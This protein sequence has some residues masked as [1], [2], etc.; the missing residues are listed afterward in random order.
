V[1]TVATRNRHLDASPPGNDVVGIDASGEWPPEGDYVLIE[2]T[3]TGI[4]MSPDILARA[5]EPFFTTKAV[6]T[7]SGLGLSQVFGVARQSG[8]GMHIESTLGKG[9]SVT[10]FVPRG[11]AE[12]MPVAPAAPALVARPP[13]DVTVLL[14]DDDSP[15]R[16]TTA[17]IVRGLGYTVV[18]AENGSEALSVLSG[19][20]RVDL[21]LT[22]VAMPGMSGP[23]LA[24]RAQ[25]VRPGLPTVFISGYADPQ[26]IAG[27]ARLRRFVRKPFRAADLAEHLEHAMAETAS[28]QD[29]SRQG[30][31]AHHA[32]ADHGA[33]PHG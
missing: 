8:G 31:T 10:V 28:G 25:S 32:A 11:A 6:G 5:I 26:T 12:V 16:V 20:Q 19:Q 2:V 14:V 4:G 33:R 1:V 22:D 23:E 15:V 30:E 24:Q 21:L 7:G 3:D 29:G 18:E 9:T 13:I 17:Q 27:G